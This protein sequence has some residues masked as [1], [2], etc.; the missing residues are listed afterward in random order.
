MAALTEGVPRE[1]ADRIVERSGGNPFF[2]G[3]LVRAYAER[4][5]EGALDGDIVLPDTVHATV[6]ARI[7]GLAADERSI[8]EFAAAAGRT[9][10]APAIHALLPE[11]AEELIVQTLEAL[12]ERD[13]LVPQG[14][15]A[16]TFRHIV[17]REV[18]YAT[19]PRAER[20]RA[21]LRLARWLEESAPSRAN[22]LAELVAY[23]YRQAIAMSPGGRVPEGL[24]IAT[25]GAALER[26]AR[27][28]SNASA[29]REAAEQLREAVRLAPPQEHLRLLELRG[30]LLIFGNDAIAGYAEAYE[31]WRETPQPDRR[32]GARLVVKRLAVAGR[33]SGSLGKPMD[34]QEFARLALEARGL[35]DHTP[36]EMLDAKLACAR[37][38]EVTRGA[39]LEPALLAE[40]AAS[41][42]GAVALF[43]SRG[44]VEAESEALDALAAIHRGGY[45]DS[46]MALE[47]TRK[48]LANLA[49]L[50]LLERIDAWSVT[51][52]ELVYLGRYDE[53]VGTYRDARAA[54]RAGE[55]EYMLAHAAS[56]AAY[57]AML[58]GRWDDALAFGDALIAIREE[59][60]G[61]IARFTFQ[62]WVG[63]I[64][65]AAARLDTTRLARYRSA[66][67]AI[68]EVELLSEPDRSLWTAFIAR[69]GA[70]ARRY[71][72]A[73]F[74]TPDRK[75]EVLAMIL[76][77]LGE[78]VG[79]DILATLER[80]GKI[81][82]P[83]CALRI[84]LARA[85]NQGAG[86]LRQ[87][88]AALD[89]GHLVADA[90]RAA[91]LLALRTRDPA[92]RADAQ[93]RLGSLGDNAYL[94]RL[95]E[96]G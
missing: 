59:S 10:R 43:A 83:V 77:D 23:H 40:L 55:P 67:T 12:V 61:I 3:E 30:D 90:A 84:K 92:D 81:D 53:A 37:A 76:V 94:Q 96:D 73:P 50:S 64:R 95:A 15:G 45:G 32:V 16:Y 60:H 74:G 41:T 28:A 54:L 66:F 13:L 1:T 88:I 4:R 57:A 69:D 71:L 44:D 39:D 78:Q 36:D 72:V 24:P 35:L 68:A 20:V 22:E 70:A 80:R 7:D 58:C 31:R 87:A 75:G 52:W 2:A 85:L 8:L 25:V 19:L 14:A 17:I 46:S 29:F 38:F 56:W 18:A 47:V 79:E 49:R 42:Q 82:P 34:P 27:A 91:A 51:I 11:L 9:A 6:L 86:E 89:E 62:G 48:R 26:A 21:H 5:R 63:A 65:V 33:W 93:R